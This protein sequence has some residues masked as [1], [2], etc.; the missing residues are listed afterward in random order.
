MSQPQE[1]WTACLYPDTARS[2]T[3]LWR[4]CRQAGQPDVVAPI[5]AHLAWPDGADLQ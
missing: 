4:V 3:T 5:L 2:R 1:R